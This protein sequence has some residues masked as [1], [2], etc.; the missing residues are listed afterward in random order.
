MGTIAVRLDLGM[1]DDDDDD[2]DMIDEDGLLDDN[3]LLAPPPAMGAQSEANGDD[4]AGRKPCDDCTCGR[5]EREAGGAADCQF[6]GKPAF[7]PGE[8]HVVLNLMD[9]L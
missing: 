7:K 8:E 5:A 6:L 4:C 2:A 3:N 9:D 1:M